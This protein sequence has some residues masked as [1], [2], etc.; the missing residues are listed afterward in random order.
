MCRNST[1]LCSGEFVSDQVIDAVSGFSVLENNSRTIDTFI[2]S[3][4]GTN[5]GL[6]WSVNLLFILTRTPNIT[7]SILTPL[8]QY[9]FL[10]RRT[11]VSSHQ[12]Y[13][14]LSSRCTWA[15]CSS[16]CYG[17]SYRDT[18]RPENCT[19]NWERGKS[20]AS[21]RYTRKVNTELLRS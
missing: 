6:N 15:R 8:N 4:Y 16:N 9:T 3:G 19:W 13:S 7:F 20:Q 21:R 2:I 11:V 12:S 5:L 18:H 1:S 14:R 17:H 10:H